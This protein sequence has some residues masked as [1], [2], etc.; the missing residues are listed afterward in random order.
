MF[1]SKIPKKPATKKI[2]TKF[3]TVLTSNIPSW[4]GSLISKQGQRPLPVKTPQQTRSEPVYYG[5]SEGQ[6]GSSQWE[7]TGVE[8][9]YVQASFITQVALPA[10]TVILY[11]R[12]NLSYSCPD[13]SDISVFF[14]SS[15]GLTAKYRYREGYPCGE[16][17][18]LGSRHRHANDTN[19]HEKVSLAVFFNRRLGRGLLTCMKKSYE[20]RLRKSV[21]FTASS[22]DLKVKPM[23]YNSR[24]RSS[25][26]LTE[27]SVNT[28]KAD[29]VL[30]YVSGETIHRQNSFNRR[31]IYS[32]TQR[33]VS[34]ITK[35]PFLRSNRAAGA[36][37][38]QEVEVDAFCPQDL[39]W[40]VLTKCTTLMYLYKSN[41]TYRSVEKSA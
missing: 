20:N 27:F 8:L 36:K 41:R 32:F 24:K 39:C 4:S 35:E 13:I 30:L 1:V 10:P 22:R 28:V 16:G 19:L 5:T 7:G 37:P 17:K 23:S 2:A 18:I 34:H 25:R 38:V 12:L 11:S 21:T 31:I 14:L 9:P 6:F 26:S 40:H 15:K 3:Y 33:K 29:N